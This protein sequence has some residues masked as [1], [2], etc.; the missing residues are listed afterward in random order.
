MVVFAPD[1][2]LVPMVE[3]F[4]LEYIRSPDE[5]K[6]PSLRNIRELNHIVAARGIDIVH[7]YEDG[8]ALELALGPHRKFGTP[9]VTTVL[10]M[11]VPSHIPTHERLIVGTAD[12]LKRKPE[13]ET[14]RTDRPADRHRRAT[15][16]P[17]RA[18]DGHSSGSIRTPCS[19]R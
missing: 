13:S 6:R 15:H 5:N 11:S 2:E 12:L 16:R 19:S 3:Q 8:P 10:S 17:W 1:G 14:G 7:G 9:L 4:G 18:A